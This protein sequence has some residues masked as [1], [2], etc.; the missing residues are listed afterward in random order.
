MSETPPDAKTTPHSMTAPISLA[1]GAAMA[2]PP[3]KF[4]QLAVAYSV[5]TLVVIASL[6]AGMAI[7]QWLAASNIMLVFL[8]SVLISAALY[9]FRPGLWASLLSAVAGT[10]FLSSPG[11]PFAVSDPAN[12][13]AIMIFTLVA[14]FASALAEQS[15]HQAATAEAN[16]RITDQMY[17]FSQKL[18]GIA[19][20]D[21]L[22]LAALTQV[23]S[24]LQVDAL[25]LIP[26]QNN[27]LDIRIAL[28]PV[29]R[30]TFADRNAANWCVEHAKP[31]GGDLRVWP[32]ATHLFVPLRTGQGVVGVLGVNRGN[33]GTYLTPEE[34]K[35]L[36]ALANHA[37]V[38]VERAAFGAHVEEARLIRETEDFR[39]AMLSSLTHD[40]KTPLASILGTISSLRHYG[41]RYDAQTQDEMLGTAQEESERLNRYLGNLLDITRLDTGTLKP[42]SEIIDI[43]DIVGAVLKRFQGWPE[44]VRIVTA[45]TPDLPMV[46]LDF[47]LTEQALF[48]ILDNALKY[49]SYGNVVIR[50][51]STAS[52]CTIAIEDTGP[53]IP[54]EYL[55]RI[56]DRFYRVKSVD[57]Q[58]AGTGLGLAV[59]KGFTEA[60]GGKLVAS[61]RPKGGAVFSMTFPIARTAVQPMLSMVVNNP[62]EPLPTREPKAAASG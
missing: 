15:R 9:G 25:I 62:L 27:E 41:S 18:A 60:M 13:W 30:L 24:M 39:N 7:K 17:A 1:L 36:D 21:E 54:P 14:A 22:I 53:G 33:Q 19:N 59:S 47:M 5:S 28:P 45:I 49:A 43:S 31:S 16:A 10:Y 50:A 57:R 48:N 26:G 58:R 55:V 42:K 46:P 4:N 20:A 35:L 34:Y 52:T 8:P 3:K 38:T 23:H 51:T 56:F 44:G 2:K 37:A 32:D 6:I 61:N 40:F 11:D 29:D 12:F